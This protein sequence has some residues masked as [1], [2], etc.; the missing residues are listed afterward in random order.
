VLVEVDLGSGFAFHT[1]T[2]EREFIVAAR[3]RVHVGRITSRGGTRTAQECW[4]P[5]WILFCIGCCIR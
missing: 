5:T 4:E 1:T 2:G 3:R